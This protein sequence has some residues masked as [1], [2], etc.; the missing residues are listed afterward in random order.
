ME[1]YPWIPCTTNLG[2]SSPYIQFVAV[3]AAF[4]VLYIFGFLA[5][6]VFLLA[7]FRREIK[8][9]DQ[10]R[11]WWFNFLY[12]EYAPKYFYFEI[13][14]MLRR[15]VLALAQTIWGVTGEGFYF[16]VIILVFWGLLL[17]YLQPFRKKSVLYL[18]LTVTFTLVL[19]MTLSS[20]LS[21]VGESQIFLVV[22]L[23]LPFIFLAVHGLRFLSENRAKVRKKLVNSL[24]WFYSTKAKAT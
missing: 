8:S 16:S 2:I 13:I 10:S 11:T 19:S 6:C 4:T 21:L 23:F 5:F 14:M 18:D 22:I 3:S 24:M 15:L 20:V 12:Y 9:G 17:S 7:K 1:E